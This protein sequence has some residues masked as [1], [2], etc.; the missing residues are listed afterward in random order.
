M[1]HARTAPQLYSVMQA[2]CAAAP[3]TSGR[4]RRLDSQHTLCSGES[5]M[6]SV[7]SLRRAAR[8][9]MRPECTVLHNGGGM[10][11][12]EVLCCVLLAIERACRCSCEVGEFGAKLT[13]C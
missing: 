2:L 4:E 7:A 9:A 3:C 11:S 10:R 12:Q 8:L 5:L 6:L 13:K 1:Q